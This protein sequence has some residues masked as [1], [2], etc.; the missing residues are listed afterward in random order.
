[1][2]FI[3]GLLV[4]AIVALLVVGGVWVAAHQVEGVVTIPDD[5]DD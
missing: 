4:G 1:V 2:T 3:I 5:W